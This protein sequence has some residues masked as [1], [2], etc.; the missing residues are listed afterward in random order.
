MT[1]NELEDFIF[2]NYYSQMEFA[3]EDSFYSMKHQKKDLQL[4]AAKLIKKIPSPS[5]SKEYYQ[6]YLKRKKNTKSVKRSK[7]IT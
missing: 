5:N 4:F 1:V 3:K 2:K 7:I 6:C